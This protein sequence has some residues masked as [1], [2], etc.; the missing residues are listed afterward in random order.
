MRLAMP[1]PL[2]HARWALTPPFHPY[3]I[4]QSGGLFSVA[5]SVTLAG[6]RA[7]PGIIPYGARTFLYVLTVNRKNAATIEPVT[8]K[9]MKSR[10]ENFSFRLSL[11]AANPK[12]LQNALGN[13]TGV[14]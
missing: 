5:L 10:G 2:P 3:L 4:F 11:P 7:L 12:D 6:A 8:Q 9:P 14:S 1:R 13:P